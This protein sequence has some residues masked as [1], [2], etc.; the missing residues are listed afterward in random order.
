MFRNFFIDFVPFSITW[1]YTYCPINSIFVVL[2]KNTCGKHHK[3]RDFLTKQ[4]ISLMN[5]LKA[6]VWIYVTKYSRNYIPKSGLYDL[7]GLFVL[8]HCLFHQLFY[9]YLLYFPT[10]CTNIRFLWLQ[11]RGQYRRMI[12]RLVLASIWFFITFFGFPLPSLK[13]LNESIGFW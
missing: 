13:F 10:K 1:V 11:N 4:Y 2:T 12:W 7:L 6:Y 8:Y 3:E 9:K 5:S